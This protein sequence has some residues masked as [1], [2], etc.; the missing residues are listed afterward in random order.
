MSST[1]P[2]L[3]RKLGLVAATSIVV[4]IVIGTGVFLKAAIMTQTVGTPDVVLWAWIAAGVLSLAGALTYAEIGILFPKAGGEYVYLKEAYGN[5]P[6]FLFGWMRFC[7]ATPGSIAAYGVGGATFA[8]KVFDLNVVGGRTG[9][10]L[11]LIAIFSGLNCLT[12]AFGG[13]LQSIMTGMKVV[14]ISVVVLGIF[15]FSETGTFS[16]ITEVAPDWRGWSA[17]GAAMLAALWAYDGWNN[18]TMVA[19]EIKNPSRNLPLALIIGM[20]SILVIYTLTNLSYFYALDVQAV[21]A[22]NSKLSPDAY[23]VATNAAETFLGGNGI[24]FL[25]IALFFSAIGAMNGSILSGARVPY[26]MAHDGLFFKVLAKIHPKTH[27]PYV[28]VLIQA[29]MAAALASSGTFDQL[30]DYVVFCGWLFYALVTYSI[31]VFRKKMPHAERAYKA[32]GYPF[33]PILFLVSAGLLLV[34]TLI[35]SPQESILGLIII[36]TGVPVYWWMNRNG[37]AK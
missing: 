29:A 28:S 11:I 5:L 37:N 7:I 33:V 4:G 25:S 3:E 12:V 26:A 30:T 20:F 23:P 24:W 10:A 19:G 15:G 22:S 17:F 14:L 9:F 34:N 8:S 16:H 32:L 13:K 1:Q 6:A 21:A 35:T 2:H 31:F 27:V 36:A 18:V